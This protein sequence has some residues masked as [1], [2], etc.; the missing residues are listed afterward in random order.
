LELILA[1]QCTVNEDVPDVAVTQCPPVAATDAPLI[2]CLTD[3]VEA[4]ASKKALGCKLPLTNEDWIG[5]KYDASGPPVEA[6][7]LP[8]TLLARVSNRSVPNGGIAW[9]HHP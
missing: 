1:N 8:S 2:Q 9:V 7:P 5:D 6:S 4:G 3:R